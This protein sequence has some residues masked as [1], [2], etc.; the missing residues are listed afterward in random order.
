MSAVWLAVL[1]LAS[2]PSDGKAPIVP[3]QASTVAAE[4]PRVVPR[5]GIELRDAVRDAL[6]RW[7]RPTDEQAET[8]ARA[9]LVLY[10]ELA[11]DEKLARTVRC[12]YL[13]K[14]RGRL[15]SLEGQISKHLARDTQSGPSAPP[16]TAT[17]PEGRRE[18]LAQQFGGFG[19]QPGMAGG[20]MA[21]QPGL[22]GFGPQ[23]PNTGQELVDLI[24]TTIRPESWDVN[25][26]HG[27]IRF[28]GLR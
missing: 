16:A 22:G 24:Q 4:R 11:E 23:G 25:G 7:A 15:V 1:A 20:G 21:G 6:R 27:S 13:S 3:E 14:V 8:A 18:V 28:W 2:P 9:L 5:T 17:V 12:R 19:A 26:G 10:R